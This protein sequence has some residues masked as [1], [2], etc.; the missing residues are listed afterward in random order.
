MSQ[1]EKL[2]YW[3][4]F[5]RLLYHLGFDF[6]SDLDGIMTY[7]NEIIIVTFCDRLPSGTLDKKK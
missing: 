4:F 2:D 5:G 7:S 1:F 3:I 6:V